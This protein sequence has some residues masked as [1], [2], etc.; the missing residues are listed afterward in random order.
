MPARAR[1]IHKFPTPERKLRPDREDTPFDFK[2]AHFIGIGGCGMNAIAFAFLESNVEVSG[3][4]LNDSKVTRKLKKAGAKVHKG[5]AAENLGNP[6]VVLISTAVPPDNPELVEAQNRKI[7]ILHRSEGLGLFLKTRKSILVSGTHGK[8]TTSAL[9]GITLEAGKLDPWV[10]V[11][12]FVPQFDGNVWHGKGEHAVAEADESDGSFEQ[13]PVHHLIVTNMEE[14]HLD[15]WKTGKAMRDGFKRVI[16]KVPADGIILCCGNDEELCDLLKKIKRKVIL[17]G[18]DCPNAVYQAKNVKLNP[19]SSTFDLY[20]NEQHFDEFVL[21]VP[22]LHNVSNAVAALALTLELGGDLSEV[23]RALKKFHGVGRRFEIKGE[24]NDVTV[25]DDYGHHPTEIRATLK[26][27]KKAARARK[28]KLHVV[29]QPHRF[30]RTRDVMNELA[31]SFKEADRIYLTKIYAAGEKPLDGVH[32]GELYKRMP[33]GKQKLTIVKDD[34]LELVDPIFQ[35]A[36]PGDIVLTM[37]AGNIFQVADELLRTYRD[38]SS[39]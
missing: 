24:F 25:I 31:G 15:F 28:G 2:S 10:F 37:G 39:R 3:S 11:G 33:K 36:K 35:K 38:N 14:E 12:G 1:T 7:P 29:F 32:S 5:H 17:Y 21:G 18:I 30:S 27:A 8:T 19:F 23:R 6:D 16:E 9:A 22:G 4:D 34:H 20:M 26:A 13:L